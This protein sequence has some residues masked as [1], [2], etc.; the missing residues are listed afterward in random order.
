M[1]PAASV[2]SRVDETNQPQLR[3]KILRMQESFQDRVLNPYHQDKIGDPNHTDNV[4]ERLVALAEVEK[5]KTS[6]YD[7]NK[8]KKRQYEKA[9]GKLES[10]NS[11]ELKELNNPK[12]LTTV[13]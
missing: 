7:E 10:L 9:F 6:K 1:V 11:Q 13:Q 2:S 4:V 12:D 3:D 5:Y 8:K